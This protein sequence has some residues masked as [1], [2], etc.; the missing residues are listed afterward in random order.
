[1]KIALD[2]YELGRE[3]KGVGRVIRNLALRLPELLPEDDFL[4]FTKEETGMCSCPR[5][6]EHVLPG[7]GGYLRW[8][9]GPLR[10][11]LKKAGP[12][13]LVA[14]NYVLPLFCPWK[15]ILFEHD[16][17]VISHPQWYPRKYALTRRYLVRRSLAKADLVVVSSAFVEKEIGTFFKLGRGNI[18]L[19]GYGVEEKFRRPPEDEVRRWREERGLAGKKVIG[20]LGSV[21]KRRHVPELIQAVEELRREIPEAF[22]YLVGEDFG[23]L[24]GG[25]SSLIRGREWVRWDRSLAE[26]E[27]P[28][29][30]SSLDVFAYLS[31]YEGFGFPPL[32]ALACGTPPVLLDRSSLAEVFAGLA[33]MVKAPDKKEIA[34]ALRAALTEAQRRAGILAE[35]ERRRPQFSWAEAA[36]EL[37]R[38]VGGMRTR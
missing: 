25:G 32:E 12:D 8:Q 27:L 3:A 5:T 22:L 15:S 2:G 11:A 30:Y 26:E 1:M 34:V 35:F 10:R 14:F 31:E 19:I 38:L 24:D 7:R 13:L 28:V 6:E 33:V 29:F 23:V 37:A 18:R 17:S 21:F 36:R 4:I 16:I 9:N 20:F